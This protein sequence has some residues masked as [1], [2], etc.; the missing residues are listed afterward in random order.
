MRTVECLN[1]YQAL[2]YAQATGNWSAAGQDFERWLVLEGGLCS[3]HKF[4]YGAR[5]RTELPQDS[6]PNPAK[7]VSQRIQFSGSIDRAG[8]CNFLPAKTVSGRIK[9]ELLSMAGCD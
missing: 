2:L 8:N 3:R 9:Q 1:G 6:E 4:L 7:A 5:C